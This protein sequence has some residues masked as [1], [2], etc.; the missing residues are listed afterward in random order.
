MFGKLKKRAEKDFNKRVIIQDEDLEV[1]ISP[2]GLEFSINKLRLGSALGQCI[3]ITQYHQE[4]DFAWLANLNS[5]GTVCKFIYVPQPETEFIAALSRNIK[6]NMGLANSSNE[7]VEVANAKRKVETYE[8]TLDAISKNAESVGII[9]SLFFANTQDEDL[10]SETTNIVLDTIASS[11]CKGRIASCL[12][13]SAL[14]TISPYWTVQ[15]DITEVYGRV[16]LA[17]SFWCGLP[18]STA[19]F[20]DGRGYY[21]A[22]DLQQSLMIIN[23]WKRGGNRTNSN[24]TILGN[25]GSGKSTCIKHLIVNEYMLGT[26]ILVLD[27]ENEYGEQTRL[28]KGR[29]IDA[30]GGNEG[31]INP[32]QVRPAPVDDEQEQDVKLYESNKGT[33]AL[34][35]H[36]KTLEVFFRLYME[37]VT[38]IQIAILISVVEELYENFNITWSTNITLLKNEE[39]PI[40]ED[41]Y[42]LLLVKAEKKETE[43]RDF[44]D[45]EYRNL[46]ILLRSIAI[47]QDANL[48][49]GY[50]TLEA[51]EDI[52]C[53][54]TFNLQNT[55]DR[56]R[57]TQY[58]NLLTWCWQQITHDRTEKILLFIDEAYLLIDPEIIES[59]LYLRN[60]AK[61][62]RKYMGGIIVASQSIVDFSDP[63]VKLYGYALLN[64][65][66]FKV[67]YGGSGQDVKETVDAFNLTDS[68]ADV[69]R[70]NTRGMG[71]F[72]VGNKIMHFN[73]IIP[74][75]EWAYIGDRGGK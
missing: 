25:P 14:K 48:F 10:I 51:D 70:K 42:K 2:L 34:A 3:G 65:S 44:E 54:N 22:K 17:S 28:L 75:Y 35:L 64:L 57:R 20:N 52:M 68:H 32:L 38:E 60:I 31:I 45:N 18:F 40:C 58:Y 74:Q 39:F 66:D 61:R 27:P 21:F 23:T 72:S 41:L 47:G 8:K 56:I 7:P 12:Q 50:T 49:N 46:A 5:K 19:G 26:K 59:L 24:W 1:A 33:S 15:K 73:Q 13:E 53:L 9:I 67:F 62:C 16:S 71:L 69:L 6:V 11:K 36:L 4:L 29:V 43:R 55:S 63:K 37:S 30:G